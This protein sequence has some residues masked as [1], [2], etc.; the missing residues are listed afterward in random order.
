MGAL[1]GALTALASCK[2]NERS[3]S[4]V[5]VPVVAASAEASAPAPAIDAS[6]EF[7]RESFPSASAALE[8]VL[9]RTHPRILAFGEVHAPRDAHVPSAAARVRTELL[10]QLAPR[11]AA[12]VVE[13]WEPS[14]CNRAVEAKIA[15]TNQEVTQNQA[16]TNTNEYLALAE[17]AKARG[18]VPLPL[19][20]T[21]EESA[22]VADAGAA[23]LVTMLETVT[24]VAERTLTSA[25]EKTGPD[26]L[27]LYYGGALHNDLHPSAERA[28]WSFGPALARRSD[29]GFVEL[30]LVVPEF[31]KDTEVWKSLPWRSSYDVARDGATVQ[32]LSRNG[33]SFVLVFARTP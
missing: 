14:N 7:S 20:P 13:A 8:A 19:R 28:S 22:K 6:A 12:L 3:A 24:Q 2:E 27:T 31:I 5:N 26:K 18:M 32:L 9:T 23:D 10:P 21:C 30:D 15:K 16:K 4:A 25:F 17:D 29:G 1:L 33:K 11:S